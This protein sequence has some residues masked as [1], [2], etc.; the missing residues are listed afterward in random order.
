MFQIFLKI[1]GNMISG[2]AK[3]FK[4]NNLYYSCGLNNMY[5]DNNVIILDSNLNIVR[6]SYI[7]NLSD[8]YYKSKIQKSIINEWSN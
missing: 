4:N 8:M 2:R 5:N 6:T 3:I 7:K 1:T